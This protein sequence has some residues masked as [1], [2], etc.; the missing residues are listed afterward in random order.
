MSKKWDKYLRDY[1]QHCKR[2]EQATFLNI[3]E[4]AG[5]KKKRIKR[6]EKD[7][8]TWFE[9]YFPMY[10]KSKCAWYHKKMAKLIINYPKIF[11]LLE[12]FRSGAKS[13]HACMGIP[14]FL[15][16][17]GEL[18]FMLLIGQTEKKACKLISGIQSQL[19]FNQRFINDYGKKHKHGDWADGDFTTIDGVK[20]MALG[21]GQ[22]PR[23][24][25]EGAERPDYIVVDDIDKKKRCNNDKLS[26]EAYEYVYED[27][28]GCF[29]EG[30]PIQ[31]MVVANNNHHKN[32]VI[33]QLKEH[34]KIIN[35]LFDLEDDD[36]DDLLHYCLTVTAVKDLIDF[37][38][39]WPE[40]TDAQYWRRKHKKTPSR[41]FDREYMH[42]H[43]Q[44]GEIFKDEFINYKR[45]L[46]LS[47]YDA[48]CMYGDLSYK[49][50]G[51]FKSLFLMGKIGREYHILKCYV[52]RSSRAKAAIWLYDLYEDWNLKKYNIHYKIEGLFAQ[53]EFVNDFDDEGDERGYIIPVVA[54]NKGKGNKFDRIESMAGWWEKLLVFVNE[55]LKDDPD[56]IEGKDQLLAFEKGSTANDDAPDSIQSC[57]VELNEAAFVE[58]FEPVMVSR[59]QARSKDKNRF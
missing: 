43:V 34:F 46:K 51:D 29:D 23:G 44:D 24:V 45:R 4:S 8:I 15:Y 58:R 38:P 55:A 47:Q 9:Y 37:E 7:Y 5:E 35:N 28:R 25:R 49:D 17:T 41:S 18:N 53:D 14:L 3:N 12:I 16:V 48:L 21:F 52:R 32:T 10:A 19:E 57:I 1:E 27:L 40:K 54:D 30:G 50:K 31:R 56:W 33:N 39:N 13:V 42:K 26:R 59:A 20:F 6:L 11:I 2:I 36:D 22:D